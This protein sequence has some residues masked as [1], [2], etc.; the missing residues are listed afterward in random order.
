VLVIATPAQSSGVMA[1][2]SKLPGSLAQRG[3][4]GAFFCFPTDFMTHPVFPHK[5][6]HVLT[7]LAL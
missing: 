5:A 6:Q 4:F 1:R 3:L 2:A 7:F